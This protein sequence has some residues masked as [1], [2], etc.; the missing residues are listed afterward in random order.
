M[1]HITHILF[2]FTALLSLFSVLSAPF[3][4]LAGIL[5]AFFGWVPTHLP[6]A[7]WTKQLLAFSIVLLG[8]NVNLVE[9]AQLLGDNL[10]LISLSIGLAFVFTSILAKL[11]GVESDLSKLL[12]A[13][14]AI[15][16]GSAIG[17]VSPVIRAKSHVIG[18]A[19]G[20][21]FLL[22]AIALWVFPFIG[23]A[24]ELTQNQFGVWAAI[25]IHDTASV[26]AAAGEYGA[27]AQLTATTLKLARA[28]AI[29]PLVFIFVL[30]M[31]RKGVANQEKQS[32]YFPWFI[33]GF[34]ITAAISSFLPT[35]ESVYDLLTFGGKKLL[36]LAIFLI[37]ATL[38]PALIK[39]TGWRALFVATGAWMGIS[40]FSLW[41]V[42]RWVI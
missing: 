15:C 35:F 5:F 12:G 31:N 2:I 32:I 36:V 39:Q 19:L 17:A 26:V 28:L 42:T 33:G 3:A 10:L 23:H 30:L 8:F 6:L 1:I 18:V 27:S 34:V 7:K 9:A 37:G 24:F 25:A 20:C 13:G 38:S 21:V 29:V 40:L 22:N 16:G 4:L 11:L 41:W 14:T